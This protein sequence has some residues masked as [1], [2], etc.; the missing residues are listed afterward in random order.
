MRHNESTLTF[1]YTR[2]YLLKGQPGVWH[3]AVGK[4]LNNSY[5]P[6]PHVRPYRKQQV[7][8][9]FWRRPTYGENAAC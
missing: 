9:Y 3:I 5:R 8:D 7:L 1:L 4:N 2:H 6:R